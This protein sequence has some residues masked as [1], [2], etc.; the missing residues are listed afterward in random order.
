MAV[1][2]PQRQTST[3]ISLIRI[4]LG[5]GYRGSLSLVRTI[6]FN[7]PV[8][9]ADVHPNTKLLYILTRHH[10][11]CYNF[12]L[13][14]APKLVFQLDN[15]VN[16]LGMLISPVKMVLFNKITFILLDIDENGSITS[17]GS[18]SYPADDLNGGMVSRDGS[19]MAFSHQTSA[20][21]DIFDMATCKRLGTFDPQQQLP[22]TSDLTQSLSVPILLIAVADWFLICGGDFLPAGVIIELTSPGEA[23]QNVSTLAELFPCL[24][25]NH[26]TSSCM[27]T[28]QL[29]TLVAGFGT[30]SY[31]AR[32]YS[33]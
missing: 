27:I 10:V 15:L 19:V 30:N 28:A 2:I 8:I 16:P 6:D 23:D 11:F 29:P 32:P 1:C 26:L 20:C 12:Q 24:E 31:V 4:G 13:N 14:I 9:D 33:F 22:S 21:I 25:E 18:S 5:E 3:Q 17:T 7:L